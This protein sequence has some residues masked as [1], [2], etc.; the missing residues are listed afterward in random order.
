[1]KHIACLSLL[2]TSMAHAA[3]RPNIIYIFT[4]QH[5]ANAMSC[6]GNPDLHT[7]NL[8]RLAAAG[9]MFQNAYCTAP[10]SGP[11]RGAMFT[12]CY[13]GTTGLLVNG[14]PLQES[15]QTRTL[16]T[17]VKNA[18][19][20]CA[21]GGKWHV[22]ELDIPD[23]VRGF[24]QIYKHSDDGLAEA[25]VEF[26]SRKHDKPFFL[27]ASYDNPHNI[28]EYARSQNLPYVTAWRKAFQLTWTYPKYAIVRDFPLT[29]PRTHTMPM[30]SR[31]KGKTI[32]TSTPPP[33]SPPKTGVCTATHTTAS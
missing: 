8:D 24:D 9:I 4:D 11:S 6:A 18:G 15:L 19:Y 28:C 17:L 32:S 25:C 3:E 22:P 21:Y 2:S 12:G 23:K 20:E 13:P 33:L 7:P 26:L 5:T 31:K 10:L 14:A 29:L 30:S 16:G 1:M 27:V